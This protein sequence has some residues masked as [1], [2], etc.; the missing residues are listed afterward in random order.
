MD[1]D[2]E[3]EGGALGVDEAERSKVHT[4][5]LH[6]GLGTFQVHI[7]DGSRTHLFDPNTLQRAAQAESLV[8]ASP[9]GLSDLSRQPAYLYRT[10]ELQLLLTKGEITR[11]ALH[12][13]HPTEVLKLRKRFGK[14]FEIDDDFYDG[15]TGEPLA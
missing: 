3:T 6:T 7:V 1:W 13:L 5:W 10:H 9:L 12:C 11:L 4:G 14:F 15:V 8:F 2:I